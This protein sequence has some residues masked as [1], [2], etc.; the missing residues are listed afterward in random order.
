[1]KTSP[2]GNT[3]ALLYQVK[4]LH[5]IAREASAFPDTLE[6]YDQRP[7]SVFVCPPAL[8][9]LSVRV[10]A[11]ARGRVPDCRVPTL[12]KISKRITRWNVGPPHTALAS[13]WCQPNVEKIETALSQEGQA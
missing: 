13:L 2:S 4:D 9:K 7:D 6:N 3:D 5:L 1:M 10:S 8:E 11:T 12:Q